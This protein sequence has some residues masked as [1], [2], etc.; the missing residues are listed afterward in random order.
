VIL[1][2]GVLERGDPETVRR[3]QR[4][5]VDASERV[6]GSGLELAEIRHEPATAERGRV[7][8]VGLDAAGTQN[9]LDG[10]LE[11]VHAATIR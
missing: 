5:G 4:G 2:P 10:L 7:G 1:R 6:A 3:H 11:T 8:N 9:E